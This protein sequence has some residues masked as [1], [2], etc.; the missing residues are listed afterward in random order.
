MKVDQYRVAI[1]TMSIKVQMLF[2]AYIIS[3]FALTTVFG[4]PE[5]G[6]DS[7]EDDG[8][9]VDRNSTVRQKRWDNSGCLYKG[10]CHKGWC[11]AYCEGF[12]RLDVTG[13]EEL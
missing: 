1:S 3:A 5:A 2:V 8:L 12:G 6:I 9:N 7:L 13:S 11:W 4:R 10:G